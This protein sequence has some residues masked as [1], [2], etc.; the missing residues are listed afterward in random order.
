MGV[1]VGSAVAGLSATRLFRNDSYGEQSVWFTSHGNSADVW[2]GSTSVTP[3]SNGIVFP[4]ST[5]TVISVPSGETLWCA[6]NGTDVLR[7]LTFNDD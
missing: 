1:L 5:T 4:K 7:W 6:G 3:T 2:V